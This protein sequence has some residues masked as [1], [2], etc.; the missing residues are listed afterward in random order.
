MKKVKVRDDIIT[1]DKDGVTIVSG[2]ILIL[3]PEDISKNSSGI[4]IT[5][6]KDYQYSGDNPVT[7]TQRNIINIIEETLD[8][9][10]T[11]TTARSA[12]AFIGKYYESAGIR[13]K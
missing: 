13:K 10:F 9:K 3:G 8:V 12:Y 7:E 11:G 4:K 1:Y 6:S 2:T 5:G